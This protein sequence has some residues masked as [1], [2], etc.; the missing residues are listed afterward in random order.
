MKILKK[1]I[2]LIRREGINLELFS[3][4]KNIKKN[5]KKK[6]SRVS[7]YK[8]KLREFSKI[9]IKYCVNNSNFKGIVRGIKN[10]KKKFLMFIKRLESRLDNVLYRIGFFGTRREARQS[11]AHKKIYVNERIIN[12]PSYLV[13][14]NDILMAKK[15]KKYRNQ[16]S[17]FSFIIENLCKIKSLGFFKKYC[18]FFNSFYVLSIINR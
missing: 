14:K 8:K 12:K 9:K 11:I 5:I 2:K 16:I 3:K 13:K 18:N 6:F 7:E 4:K 1:K 15:K 10:S 17:K